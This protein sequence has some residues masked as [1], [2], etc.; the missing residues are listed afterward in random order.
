MDLARALDFW[1][2]HRSRTVF[3]VLIVFVDAS[4]VG[5]YFLQP[6]RKIRIMTEASVGHKISYAI[7]YFDA[8]GNPMIA[9][10]SLDA[11]PTWSNAPSDPSVD[12]LASSGPSATLSLLAAGTDA[13]SV[14]LA[15]GGVSFSAIDAVTIDAAPQVL[16]SIALVPTVS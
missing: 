14:S 10:P 6:E 8:K 5:I 4:C 11:P 7:A 12:S 9:A 15:V 16:G 13:V 1:R 3:V 2:R